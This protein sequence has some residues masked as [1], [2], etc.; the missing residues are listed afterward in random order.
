MANPRD[1]TMTTEQHQVEALERIAAALE[2]IA[3]TDSRSEGHRYVKFA[4]ANS[5]TAERLKEGGFEFLASIYCKVAKHHA[6]RAAELLQRPV[7]EMALF[8]QPERRLTTG[9]P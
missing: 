8:N 2:S 7:E 6:D 3:G 9:D 4:L 1:K 5:A